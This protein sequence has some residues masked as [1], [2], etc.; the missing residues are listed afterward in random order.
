MIM[1]TND[2]GYK[3]KGLRKLVSLV[4]PFG[5][6]VVVSTERPMSAKGHSI[7]ITEPLRLHLT[8]SEEGY[9]EYICNGTPADCIK[10]GQQVVGRPDLVLSGINHG[11]NA[12]VNAIYSGT[13]AAVVEG[14]MNGYPSVGFSVDEYGADIC[15]DHVDSALT[16]IVGKVL[17]EGLPHN[18]CLNV[19]FPKYSGKPMEGIR[20]CRQSLARWVE[21]LDART[22]PYGSK[23]YWL[24]GELK[25]NDF[26]EDTDLNALAN[27]YVSV[28]PTCFDWTSYKTM[29]YIKN[30]NL[31]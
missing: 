19:N 4:R 12:S 8:A 21:E 2:D 26:G 7:T 13:I 23:Y 18:V 24:T 25:Q 15:F 17:G 28:V 11:S 22:D 6:V 29:D 14:C 9:T 5:D 30:W 10:I 1:I 31:K 3:A 27:N 16:E 20:V